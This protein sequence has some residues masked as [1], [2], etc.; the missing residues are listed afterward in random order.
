MYVCTHVW[1]SDK[2][3]CNLSG[4]VKYYRSI[5]VTRTVFV[6]HVLPSFLHAFT[7][8]KFAFYAVSSVSLPSVVPL[9]SP[10]ATQPAV[11]IFTN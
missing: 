6:N 4:C 9:F 1:R 5:V 8:Q 3:N 7:L 11:N 2:Y 10:D